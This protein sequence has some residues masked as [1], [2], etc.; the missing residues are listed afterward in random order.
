MSIGLYLRSTIDYG[1][2]YKARV[3]ALLAF[4]AIVNSSVNTTKI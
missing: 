2:Y 4:K 1:T 3:A